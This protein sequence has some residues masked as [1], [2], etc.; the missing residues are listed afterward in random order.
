MTG[1]P[2]TAAPERVAPVAELEAPAAGQNRAVIVEDGRAAGPDQ[3][4]RTAFLERLEG[5]VRS[6]VDS[7]LRPM[8]HSTRGC[9]Y[10]VRYLQRLRDRPVAELE[11]AVRLWI[12]PRR[13]AP[14]EW[15]EAIGTRSREAA[16]AWREG[17]SDPL[18]RH[19][20]PSADSDLMA[21]APRAGASADV[22]RSARHADPRVVM[23]HLGDGRPLPAP[24]RTRAERAFRVDFSRVRIHV[25]ELA[26]HIAGASGARAFT[27][28]QHIGFASGEYRPGTRI[29]DV[30]LAH[31]L[32]HTI[33]QRG[34]IGIAP[35]SG[36]LEQDADRAALAAA[37]GSG[38]R[39]VQGRGLA[40]QLFGCNGEEF[41]PGDVEK[42]HDGTWTPERMIE[43]CTST[44]GLDEDKLGE[45]LAA[46]L[47]YTTADHA[48]FVLRVFKKLDADDRDDVAAALLSHRLIDDPE[49]ASIAQDEKGRRIL[50]YLVPELTSGWTFPGADLHA[51][52]RLIRAARAR[53][54]SAEAGGTEA[55]RLSK[56]ALD[57]KPEKASAAAMLQTQLAAR[58]ALVWATL[59]R[60]AE[61]WASDSSVTAAVASARQGWGGAAGATKANMVRTGFAQFALDLLEP[62]LLALDVQIKRTRREKTGTQG[63]RLALFEL[64]RIHVVGAVRALFDSTGP[65]KLAAA[66][67]VVEGLSLSLARI[68]VEVYRQRPTMFADVEPKVRELQGFAAWTASEIEAVQASQPSGAAARAAA[69]ERLGRALGAIRMLAHW[70][71]LI[72]VAEALESGFSFTQAFYD[73]SVDVDS[74]HT[75]LTAMASKAKSGSAAELRKAV[76]AFAADPAIAEYYSDVPDILKTSALAIALAVTVVAAAASAGVGALA[77]PAAGAGAGAAGAAAAGASQGLGATIALTALDALVFTTVSQAAGAALGVQ[78]GGSFLEEFLWNFGMFG[79][80]RVAGRFVGTTMKA[81]GFSRIARSAALTGT[82]V[83]VLEGYG[84]LRFVLE[85]GRMPTGAELLKMNAEMVVVLA[86]LVVVHKVVGPKSTLARFDKE[87][88][89]EF[90]AIEKDRSALQR[91]I[92]DAARAGTLEKQATA[93]KSRAEALETRAEKWAQRAAAWPKLDALR[94]ELKTLEGVGEIGRKALA[95]GLGLPAEV[96]VERAGT[97]NDFTISHGESAR[98]ADGL[99]AQGADVRVTKGGGGTPTVVE[100]RFAGETVQFAERPATAETKAKAEVAKA[101]VAKEAQKDPAS[102]SAAALAEDLG[103][104]VGPKDL[105]AQ[106]P[107]A[108]TSEGKFANAAV[109][110][111]YQGY[112]DRGGTGDRGVWMARTGGGP[113][114]RL[115]AW[116]GPL[117]RAPQS[118]RVVNRPRLN[119]VAGEKNPGAIDALIKPF[120]DPVRTD[121]RGRLAKVLKLADTDPKQAGVEFQEVIAADLKATDVQ[122]WGQRPHR[123]NDIGGGAGSKAST[124]GIEVTI[125][126][127]D[128]SLSTSKLDQLWLDLEQTGGITLVV[129]KL[130]RAARLQLFRLIKQFEGLHPGEPLD[131]GIREVLPLEPPTPATP[132]TPANPVH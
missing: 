30:V 33:Q 15:M 68:E 104:P 62:Q 78:G 127:R 69:E 129:P 101:E 39:I 12:Q 7:V 86:A 92:N 115:R 19:V 90:R 88:G 76:D 112:R 116:L 99:R 108:L 26:Q 36:A 121:L 55:L 105:A 95:E 14:D 125:E 130:S 128:G 28:G 131:I 77:A 87:F 54:A 9:P 2:D 66:E 60:M 74:I 52:T 72:Q 65:Q 113:L 98:V 75:R 64:A 41:D 81:R 6:S 107:K 84:V 38:S 124:R 5:T 109:E 25:D 73:N 29:G 13:D 57:A 23:G 117:F 70:D 44:T 18:V 11:A 46:M 50:E 126:G 61:T 51:A 82:T 91:D 45:M 27:V 110:A 58:R 22:A 37:T 20:V 48:D 3:L 31:E 17:R 34:S 103:T 71:V 10:L 97:A 8:G 43:E 89:A 93:L 40:L 120:H 106:F 96:A 42:F 83:T 24:V 49:L 56:A 16:I 4:T 119:Q 32:A 47:W 1:G 79:V 114:A 53:T 118:T 85:E 100:G 123:R 122:E 21:T 132:G 111:D 59:N 80:L 35:A 102:E 67:V 94:A 63:A